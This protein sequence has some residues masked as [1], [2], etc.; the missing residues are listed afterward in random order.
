MYV[1]IIAHVAFDPKMR[2]MIRIYIDIVWLSIGCNINNFTN[3]NDNDR[4]AYR[5]WSLLVLV[6]C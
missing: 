5:I 4:E 2:S 1:G 6:L 3:Y